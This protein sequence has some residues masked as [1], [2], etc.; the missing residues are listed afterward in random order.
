MLD[1]YDAVLTVAN[2]QEILGIGRN[3][4]YEMLNAGTIPALRIG[5]QWRIPKDAVLF[6]LGQWRK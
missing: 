5:K 1:Q 6:Y 4:V 3:T 2:L